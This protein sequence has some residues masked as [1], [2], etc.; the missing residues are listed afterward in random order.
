MAIGRANIINDDLDPNDS[1]TDRD[2]T[3]NGNLDDVGRTRGGSGGVGG[4]WYRT[5]MVV[6]RGFQTAVKFR[7]TGNAGLRSGIAVVLQNEHSSA[8]G[9]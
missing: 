1:F 7:M 6:D 9:M 4:C 8:L 5:K 3:G 2:S